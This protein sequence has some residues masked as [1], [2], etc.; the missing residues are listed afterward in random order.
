MFL[1]F[2]FFF[3]FFFFLFFLPPFW[4]PDDKSWT[5]WPIALKFSGNIA[6][7][8]PLCAIVFRHFP[9]SKMAARCH[10]L[11]KI[12]ILL[13]IGAVLRFRTITLERLDRLPW[14]FQETLH[15]LC[16]CALLFFDIFRNP[17]WP[18]SAILG[19]NFGHFFSMLLFVSGNFKLKKKIFFLPLKIF[20]FWDLENFREF[21]FFWHFFFCVYCQ[22]VSLSYVYSMFFTCGPYTSVLFF[23]VFIHKLM[24]FRNFRTVLVQFHACVGILDLWALTI[25]KTVFHSHKRPEN[26]KIVVC[27][28][29]IFVFWLFCCCLYKLSTVSGMPKAFRPLCLVC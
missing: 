1:S 15:V 2:F 27:E 11:G 25:Q 3:F 6:S 24:S 8:L 10:F 5:P 29:F 7:T 21:F 9:K 23:Y 14:N 18:P 20:F 13:C 4:F 22:N 28:F 26:P 19:K 16:H 17:R 12:G